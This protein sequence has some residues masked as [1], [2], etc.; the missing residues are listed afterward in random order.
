MDKCTK[1]KNLKVTD[2]VR[3][4]QFYFI[5]T[6]SRVFK[7]ES[8]YKTMDDALKSILQT[9]FNLFTYDADPDDPS[10]AHYY[11]ELKLACNIAIS[12]SAGVIEKIPEDATLKQDLIDLIVVII[13]DCNLVL[14][15]I[16]NI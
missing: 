2:C 10:M 11:R 8:S 3:T 6:V 12:E 13:S 4:D 14:E 5:L 7:D 9:G 16:P 15:I 1:L